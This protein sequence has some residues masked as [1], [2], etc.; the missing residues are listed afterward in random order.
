MD[1]II[2][3]VRGTV[4][5]LMLGLDFIVED[6]GNAVEAWLGLAWLGYWS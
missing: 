1:K 5:G 6:F 4:W 3:S 2:N